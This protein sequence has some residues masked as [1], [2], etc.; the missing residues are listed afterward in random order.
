MLR[1]ESDF[2]VQFMQATERIDEGGSGKRIDEAVGKRY[3]LKPRSKMKYAW[4]YPAATDKMIKLVV[5]GRQRNVNILEI[6]PSYLSDSH[7]L[8]D[9][10]TASFR[11]MCVQTGPTQTLVLSNWEEEL[12]NFKLKRTTSTMSRS[13][14]V[15][16]VT[17]RD[18]GFEAVDVDTN[19]LTA[20]NLE[21]E[22]VGISLINQNIQELA[23]ISFRGLELHYTESQV[24]TAVNV[25]CKWI[26]I[27]NQLFGGLFPIVL[28]RRC[29]QRMA[30]IW[31]CIRH[32]KLRSSC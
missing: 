9:K 30:K 5:N 7:Q 18:A 21:F 12:S 14:T 3:E 22:G 11:W 15:S 31:K 29:C 10:A 24:T 6:G 20:F 32:C 16:S 1:N 19:I 25:I 27:D 23:Y 17:S 4:D 8:T 28:Y 13:D 2:T 26:Q